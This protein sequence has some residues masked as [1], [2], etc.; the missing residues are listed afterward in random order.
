[1]WRSLRL[2]LGKGGMGKGERGVREL[3]EEMLEGLGTTR[4]Q[5]RGW[6]EK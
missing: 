5:V 4:E 2:R 3:A 6:L 1:M